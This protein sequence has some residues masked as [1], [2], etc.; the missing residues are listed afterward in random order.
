[1]QTRTRAGRLAR[2]TVA[3]AAALTGT[4]SFSPPAAQAAGP[5]VVS[6]TF[7]DGLTSQYKLK[8]VLAA[9]GVRATFYIN[10]GAV[11]ARGGFGTMSWDWVRDLALAGHEIGGHTRDH[12][13]ISGDH[14]TLAEKW[15]QACDDRARLVE[16]GFRP[17][18]FAYPEGGTDDLAREI[19]QGCGYQSAR[20]AGGLL[21]TGPRYA[22]Q[23]P[24]IDGPLGIRI[25]GTTDN[26][27][28]TLDY[29]KGAVEAANA[30]GGGWLPML[31]HR[32]CYKANAD[33]ADCM[34]KYRS[35]DAAV[36]ED[37]LTWM[38]G[39]KA[40]GM[41]IKP[42]SEVLNG[43]V[44]TPVVTVTGPMAGSTVTSG[45]PA[46]SGRANGAGP[47]EIR[48]F[49]GAY[50]MG[51]PLTTLSATP[52]GGSWT[53]TPSSPL[54]QGTYTA[55]ASQA[56]NGVTGTSLPVT[57]TV[58]APDGPGLTHLSRTV[59][60]Q[61]AGNVS[62]TLNGR[63]QGGSSVSI[64]GPGVK[65]RV[66]SISAGTIGLKVSVAQDAEIS[67][68]T[69]TVV[70]RDG[71]QATCKSCLD[72]VAGP[73]ISSVRGKAVR[74][75]TSTITVNGAGFRKSTGVSVSGAGVRVTSVRVLTETRLRF[76]VRV[77]AT[78]RRTARSV[79]VKDKA[80]LGSSTMTRGLTIR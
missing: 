5:V 71:D 65:S 48:I 17:V 8:D 44:P 66:V 41:S 42:V 15:Q 27:P 39:Q 11:D 47:V 37:F 49:K 43:G 20:K 19:L 10:S 30:N 12:V 54:P 67:R 79:V 62:V 31:F 75:R 36:I 9:H 21:P 73:K 59:L 53:A 23:T 70:D 58:G 28:I 51:A 25:L 63:F 7:D 38:D 68:R 3:L 24:P 60:G 45:R 16:K 13:D 76:T 64:S 32:V 29:L 22:D 40:S 78:A 46:L 69:V 77:A 2:A 6:L 80:T 26:G 74:G 72:V 55:Q 35:V 33:Y 61:G 1:M 18:T 50:S 56:S 57:F 52:G 34:A 14:L 4:M